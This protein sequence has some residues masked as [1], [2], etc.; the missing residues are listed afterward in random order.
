MVVPGWWWLED[1]VSLVASY[2]PGLL[3]QSKFLQLMY[4]PRRSESP[5]SSTI[6]AHSVPPIIRKFGLDVIGEPAE[7]RHERV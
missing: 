5:A 4:Y 2:D 3:A 1:L 7:S 6:P